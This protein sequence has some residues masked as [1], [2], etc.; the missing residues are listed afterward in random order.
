M[1]LAVM[2]GAAKAGTTSLH[3]LLTSHPEICFAAEKEP[4]F[5]SKDEIYARGIDYYCGLFDPLPHHRIA[6]DGSTTYAR[7][8]MFDKPASRIAKVFPDARIIYVL[9][10]PVARTWSHYLHRKRWSG[11]VQTFEAMCQDDESV[12]Y[13]SNY[14]AHLT[15]YQEHFSP[16]QILCVFYEELVAKTEATVSTI[17]DHLGLEPGNLDASSLPR[18]NRGHDNEIRAQ[19]TMRFRRLPGMQM[20]VDRLPLRV[21]DAAF[22]IIR[23]ALPKRVPPPEKIPPGMEES[24]R[25]TYRGPN[26]QLQMILNRELPENWN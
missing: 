8:P 11:S 14:A 15:H 4:D 23:S 26:E 10:E 13:A 12:Q 22:G 3:R 21:R 1:N 5:F 25:E 7:L 16:E 6:F 9:R 2:I 17:V 24:L 19:T 18:N 20:I